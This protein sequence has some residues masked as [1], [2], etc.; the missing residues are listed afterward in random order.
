[1]KEDPFYIFFLHMFSDLGSK[2]EDEGLGVFDGKPIEHYGNTLVMDLFDLN[3]EHIETE[4]AIIINVWMWCVHELYNVLR[5]CGQ[6]DVDS[7][8]KMN[9]AL[10]I[11]AALWIGTDQRKEDSMS[12]N[13]LYHLAE[14]ARAPF[15]QA[16]SEAG[17]NSNI[18][19]RFHDIQSKITLGICTSDPDGYIKIRSIIKQLLGLMTVP[20]VQKLIH[21]IMKSTENN[22]SDF[23]ELY[24]LAIAARV[25]VCNATAFAAMLPLFIEGD[26]KK[27]NISEAI[28]LIQ[29]IYP[30]LDMSYNDVGNYRTGEEFIDDSTQIKNLA[31][32]SPTYNVKQVRFDRLFCD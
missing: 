9:A 23:I 17:V 10:D 14:E 8:S 4:A 11:A 19:F 25:E 16:S 30:C 6:K 32:Y 27:E 22:N 15:S 3:V 31:G 7:Q 18:L 5:A 29:S 26:F 12:G 20:L 2:L 1:M 21:H 28:K 13:L 24:T